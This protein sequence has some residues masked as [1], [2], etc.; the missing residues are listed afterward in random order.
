MG[1][2][3][4]KASEWN[5]RLSKVQEE[6][7]AQPWIHGIGGLSELERCIANLIEVN[8]FFTKERGGKDKNALAQIQRVADTLTSELVELVDI[9]LLRTANR[10]R[11][12]E[13][14]RI[15]KQLDEVRKA[16]ALVQ[17]RHKSLQKAIATEY[18]TDASSVLATAPPD[19]LEDSCKK[20]LQFLQKAKEF[21]TD[22]RELVPVFLQHARTLSKKILDVVS[23]SLESGA[24][25]L[26]KLEEIA[27]SLDKHAAEVAKLGGA[28]WEK[29]EPRLKESIATLSREV[30]PGKLDNLEA[31]LAEEGGVNLSK[32]KRML[33]DIAPWGG[34]LDGE[35]KEDAGDDSTRE[36]LIKNL[37]Q[38]RLRMETKFN[39]A[40]ER[41]QD[42][43]LQELLNFASE[44]DTSVK[45]MSMPG[46]LLDL[47][48]DLTKKKAGVTLE[49]LMNRARE[50][51]PLQAE[52]LSK[53][54]LEAEAT[55]KTIPKDKWADKAGPPIWRFKLRSG[56]WKDFPTARSAEVEQCYQE[57]LRKGSPSALEER[58]CEV[59]IQVE[60]PPSRSSRASSKDGRDK[61]GTRREKC[62]FGEKCYQKNPKHRQQFCHPGDPDWDSPTNEAITPSAS[63]RLSATSE[64]SRGSMREE[65]FSLDFSLMTQVN[66]SRKAAMRP[67]NRLEGLTRIQMAT[68]AYFDQVRDFVQ[69]VAGMFSQADKEMRLLGAQESQVMKSEVDNLLRG[70]GPSVREFMS[71]AVLI[72]DIQAAEEITTH[73][74]PRGESLGLIEELKELRLRDVLKEMREVYHPGFRGQPTKTKSA[75]TIF[76]DRSPKHLHSWSLLRFLVKQRLFL[77]RKSLRATQREFK[78]VDRRRGKMRC[79]ALL[80]EYEKNSGFCEHSREEIGKILSSALSSSIEDARVEDATDIVKTAVALGCESNSM[81]DEIGQ[82]VASA[83]PSACKS[84]LGL[85]RVIEIVD[86]AI[87]VCKAVGD[88][89]LED[90]TDVPALVPQLAERAMRE[91]EADGQGV[92]LVSAIPKA[93]CSF[94]KLRSMFADCGDIVNIFL[95]R[96]GRGKMHQPSGVAYIAFKTMEGCNKAVALNGKPLKVEYKGL[97]ASVKRMVGLYGKLGHATKAFEDKFWELYQAWYLKLKL[98]SQAGAIEWAI[99]FCEQLKVDMPKWMMKNDKVEAMKK[100]QS[101]LEGGDEQTV[102][103]AVIFAKQTDYKSEAKLVSLYDEAMNKLKGMKRLPSGWQAEDLVGTDATSKMFKKMDFSDP[104]LKSFFQQMFDQTKASITTRDRSGAVPT[105]YRVERIESV[106]NVDSWSA[107]ISRRDKIVEQCQRVKGVA[108]LPLPIWESYSGPIDTC[109]GTVHQDILANCNMPQLE[110]ACNE[111]LLFHGTKPHAAELIVR[112]NFDMAFACKTGLFGAGLYFA[113]SCSKADEY[114]QPDERGHFPLIICRVTLGRM[115]YCPNADPIK[116]PGRTALE[117]SCLRGEYHSVIGDRKKARGTYREFIVYDNFQVYPTF[118]V[119]YSRL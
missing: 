4:S 43:T 41:G 74:G 45:K 104:M 11:I 1:C 22:V 84:K 65:K 30:L 40:L 25:S 49:T 57:W 79:Q 53:A 108:P 10:A 91:I 51:L 15:S 113:E 110:V 95:P 44:Y 39:D 112:N 21:M 20:V 27:A 107:Y 93:Q 87:N 77:A 46:E 64:A 37:K 59:A 81:V 28:P 94:S 36:R 82:W 69:G 71:I 2:S 106:M 98:E 70:I 56:M 50:S 55:I 119:W 12:Q 83:V 117:A 96:E 63:D 7:A 58:R 6:V 29:L 67:I 14:V 42:S 109:K 101:A 75:S 103:E 33:K 38:V 23:L 52:E 118:I 24:S 115:N 105:G 60:A 66:L 111:F 97:P 73:L 100:L 5:E 61:S 13:V 80:A 116:D 48:R 78:E 99:A 3:G 19:Q 114:V 26:N 32:L 86:L 16:S 68:K 54:R 90:I 102:R 35:K 9:N 89:S 17:D 85:A 31:E 8:E 88:R 76:G 18:L 92:V 34:A 47:S 62:K 72:S